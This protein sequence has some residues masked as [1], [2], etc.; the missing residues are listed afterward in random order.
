MK[1]PPI[2]HVRSSSPF[3]PKKGD[4]LSR[5]LFVVILGMVALGWIL[6]FTGCTAARGHY[7]DFRDTHEIGLVGGWRDSTLWGGIRFAKVGKTAEI[8]VKTSSSK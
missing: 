7:E 4:P 3:Q 2:E 8:E 1:T 6:T 5:V